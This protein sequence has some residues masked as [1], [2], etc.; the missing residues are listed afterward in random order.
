[1]SLND[2][3]IGE[4]DP[5]TDPE[6]LMSIMET[7]ELL[8]EAETLDQVEQ[9]RNQNSRTFF[10]LFFL[11]QPLPF[12]SPAKYTATEVLHGFE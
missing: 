11:T 7:R 5:V 6:L 9:I 2:V 12:V 10:S 1:M 3:T 4:S 8:E